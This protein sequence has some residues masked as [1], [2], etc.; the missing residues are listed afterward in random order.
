MT[1][2]T[3]LIQDLDPGPGPGPGPDPTPVIE[4]VGFWVELYESMLPLHYGEAE[5]DYALMNY[6]KA[7]A[8]PFELIY[9]L[10]RD[11]RETGA[12]GWSDLFNPETCPDELLPWLRQFV[13]AAHIRGENLV[14]LRDRIR[15]A[16][17]FKRGTVES[18]I[19][20]ANRLGMPSIIIDE[21]YNGSAW[22]IQLRFEPGEYTGQRMYELQKK[23]PAGI[24]VTVN[25]L[26][27]ITFED[28][29]TTYATFQDAKAANLDFLDLKGG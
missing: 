5:H 24:K 11:N 15:S 26:S 10:V 14:D 25:F 23:I 22:Q 6:C 9:F 28:I 13:G 20:T 4:E 21:R 1:L 2:V 3:T 17:A 29:R 7:V 16:D 27:L 12:S 19:D 18:I 8:A